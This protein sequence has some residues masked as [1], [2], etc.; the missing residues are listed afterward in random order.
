MMHKKLQQ[1]SDNELIRRFQEYDCQQSF[2]ELIL[3]YKDRVYTGIYYIVK[4]HYLAE[5]I[6]QETLIKAATHLRQ[7]RYTHQ[8]KFAPWITRIAHN[9]CIDTIRRSK[10]SHAINTVSTESLL[11]LANLS[12]NQYHESR[13]ERKETERQVWELINKLPQEQMEVVM[14][15]VYGEMSFKEISDAMGVSINTSLG[16]MRYALINL[17]KMIKERQLV[18]R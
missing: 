3:R 8:G 10:S 14:M 4:D 18:L 6:F 1:L 13:I 2:K 11:P 9:M 17:R 7:G 5:D 16:R 12:V 15:R